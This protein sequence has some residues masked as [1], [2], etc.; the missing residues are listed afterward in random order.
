M[1][2]TRCTPN[3][4]KNL[5]GYW[6]NRLSPASSQTL[7]IESKVDSNEGGALMMSAAPILL[8]DPESYPQDTKINTHVPHRKG[9]RVCNLLVFSQ[10]VR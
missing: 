7:F 6:L 2:L 5:Q 4:L 1:H 9:V 10:H 3:H 8:V